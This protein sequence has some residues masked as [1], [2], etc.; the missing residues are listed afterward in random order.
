MGFSTLRVL[1][2]LAKNVHFFHLLHSILFNAMD[3]CRLL[4]GNGQTK[5]VGKLLHNP[6]DT[7]KREILRQK[8]PHSTENS[9]VLH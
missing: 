5:I 4:D 7:G 2:I 1:Y 3:R 9:S 8:F 6:A